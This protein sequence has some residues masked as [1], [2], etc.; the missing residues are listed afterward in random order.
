MPI[1]CPIKRLD[2]F[3][4]ILCGNNREGYCWALCP[5]KELKKPLNEILTLEERLSIL[6]DKITNIQYLENIENLEERLVSLE[7]LTDEL[8]RRILTF[9]ETESKYNTMYDTVNN[10]LSNF[11]KKLVSLE[12]TKDSNSKYNKYSI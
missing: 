11:S 12:N 10:T 1:N 5:P 9:K 8:Q 3:D 6:E 4:C 7:S 2:Y